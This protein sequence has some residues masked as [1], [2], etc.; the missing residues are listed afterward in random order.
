MPPPI[1]KLKFRLRPITGLLL[2]TIAALIILFGLPVLA[3][4]D[5]WFLKFLISLLLVVALVLGLTEIRRLN[6]RLA[7]LS[8]VANALGQG[9]YD[10]RAEIRGEDSVSL[11][12]QA[13][14]TMAERIAST[15]SELENSHREL[16]IS[17]EKMAAQNKELSEAYD[18]QSCFG[19]FLSK[20]NAID[21]DTLARDSFPDMVT[22]ARAQV[23]VLLLFDEGSQQLRRVTEYG[24]DRNALDQLIPADGF[25]GLPGEAFTRREWILI[26]EID[27]DA[28]PEFNLGFTTARIQSLYAIPLLFHNR[29]LGVVILASMNQSSEIIT[30]TLK[31]YTR[32]LAHAFNNALTHKAVQEQTDQFES[33]NV[34]LLNL[35]HH[36]R[37]FVANMSHELRTPLNSI[38]G[39]SNIMLKNRGNAMTP[40]NLSRV[41]KINRNGVHLLQLINDIL[42]LSKIEA[43]RM[44]TDLAKTELAPL[45]REVADM[46]QPQAGAK[47]IDLILEL[48]E[49]PVITETDSQKLRQVLINLANN[50]IKF[51]EQG[52]VTLRL[53][54]G[55][56]THGPTIEIQDTG[57]G[58]SDSKLE[59]VFEAFRQADSTTSR[60]YGGTGLGL[61]ISRNLLSLLGGKIRVTSKLGEGSTFI[62]DFPNKSKSVLAIGDP[63]QDDLLFDEPL[64][65]EN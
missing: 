19:R 57:I 47:H 30:Q 34:K 37:E 11:V 55:G 7:N 50:A 20:L 63:N 12:A 16:A 62:I 35:D 41:E 46:L 10:A 15:I 32:A 42:D 44:E 22:A 51:T 58:I 53:I 48:P 28:L 65:A 52:S 6:Y 23:G 40:D 56:S 43:G 39:F 3:S 5:E 61:T 26:D 60:K 59:T 29:A 8:R 14:N 25:A 4:A 9:K 1:S 17:Q 27:R 49:T 64:P 2:V 36:R 54:P 21:I 38:I 18:R 33:A 24:I 45:I 13:L 31:N